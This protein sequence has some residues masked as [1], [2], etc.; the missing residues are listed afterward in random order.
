MHF[1]TRT[2]VAIL[3]AAA[4]RDVTATPQR[5]NNGGNNNNNNGNDNNDNNNGGSRAG[6]GG[7]GGNG[8][9]GGNESTVRIQTAAN[10]APAPSQIPPEVLAAQQSS[11]AAAAS[12]IAAANEAAAATGLRQ[13]PGLQANESP[14]SLRPLPGLATGGV[15]APPA[16]VESTAVVLVAPTL[17]ASQPAAVATE[18]PAGGLRQP[19]GLVDAGTPVSL[20]PLP[21]PPSV[22]TSVS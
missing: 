6:N 8:R 16:V 9:N 21:T 15:I 4:A 22:V 2:F 20:L 11:A 5:D 18:S 13:P 17:V 1:S 7:N 10:T 14:V 3:L 12:A 19:P